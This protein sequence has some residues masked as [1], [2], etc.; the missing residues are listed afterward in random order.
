MLPGVTI[1][2]VLDIRREHDGVIFVPALMDF[3]DRATVYKIEVFDAATRDDPRFRAAQQYCGVT[4]DLYSF[5]SIW[6]RSRI[7][8]EF[9]MRPLVPGD[10]NGGLLQV[11]FLAAVRDL[12]GRVEIHPF[13]C[14]DVSLGGE[15]RFEFSRSCTSPDMRSTVIAAF[16]S[17]LLAS[18]ISLVPFQEFA[19]WDADDYGGLAQVGIGNDGLAFEHGLDEIDPEEPEFDL[20]EWFDDMPGRE[21][22]DCEACGGEGEENFCP[23]GEPCEICGGT[24]RLSWRAP[25]PHDLKRPRR[26]VSLAFN[27]RS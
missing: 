10:D 19:A 27:R 17:L 25:W 15:P 18:P 12:F 3:D 7:M 6:L 22:H 23:V 9:R 1:V 26:S 8:A 11:P 14:D 21:G 20:Y 2:D 24:G 5:P 4:G 13:V 16:R